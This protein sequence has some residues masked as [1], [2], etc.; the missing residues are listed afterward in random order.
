VRDGRL[1]W[2]SFFSCPLH[3][4]VLVVV[5]RR[6]F[7]TVESSRPDKSK[8]LEDGVTAILDSFTE[9][10]TRANVLGNLFRTHGSVDGTE[11]KTKL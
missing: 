8:F 2:R 4:H 11:E 5:F 10:S 3:A 6:K 1:R 7:G 9:S